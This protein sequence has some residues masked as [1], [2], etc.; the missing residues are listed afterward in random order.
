MKRILSA[1]LEQT[2]RFETEGDYQTYIKGLERKSV[3][4]K[5][6]ENQTGA[7]NSITA[8]M[9]RDYNGYPVGDYLN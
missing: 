9:I 3:K 1:C 7:D 6:M 5:I 2:Q 8:K 4:Y